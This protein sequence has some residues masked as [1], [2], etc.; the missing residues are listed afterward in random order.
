MVR[1]LAIPIKAKPNVSK[2]LDR[3]P[4]CVMIYKD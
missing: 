4:R 1:S 2:E 3:G